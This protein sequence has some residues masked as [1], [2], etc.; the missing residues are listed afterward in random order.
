MGPKTLLSSTRVCE[1]TCQRAKGLSEATGPS[2]QI[3]LFESHMASCSESELAAALAALTWMEE[4]VPSTDLFDDGF[5][6]VRHVILEA[7]VETREMDRVRLAPFLD[8]LTSLKYRSKVPIQTGTPRGGFSTVRVSLERK[9]QDICI[10]QDRAIWLWALVPKWGAVQF[11][12]RFLLSA[13]DYPLQDRVFSACHSVA[14]A[15]RSATL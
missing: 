13:I 12:A 14:S 9:P 8:L 4:P 7:W 3:L 15:A 5:E 1:G 11:S 10:L 2:S 6:L